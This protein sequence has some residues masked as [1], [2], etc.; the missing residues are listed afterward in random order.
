MESRTGFKPIAQADFLEQMQ[1]E[2]IPF[3]NERKEEGHLQTTG[4]E[5]YYETYLNPQEKASI[6]ISH[7][8]CEFT[9]KFAEVIYYFYREGYSVF[10]LDHRGY[11]HSSRE[12]SDLMK[13]TIRDYDDYVEDLHQ[14]FE[15][16][17]K[18]K[19][20]T[21]KFALYG[22]SM[23]GAIAALLLEKYPGLF[24]CAV[25]TS[26]MLQM[27]IGKYPDFLA[28][29]LIAIMKLL[30]KSTAYAPGERAF[31]E[32]PE[33]ERSCCLSKERYM[34]IYE[35]RVKDQY[36]QTYGATYSWVAASLKAVKKLQKN[37]FRVETPILLFQ[38]EMDTTVKARG[39]NRF[40]A[41]TKD[42]KLVRI[43][44]SKHE[45]YNATD[46]ILAQYYPIIFQYF[47]E[48]LG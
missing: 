14:F 17:V 48:K 30:G 41:N 28:W 10:I 23:G 16:V 5:I 22:H 19:S 7:G 42:T 37:A 6:V 25:L 18:E 31:V 9:T 38:A 21:Q 34:R 4:A 44:K 20:H 8:F 45:I 33:F 36:R 35:E 3:L 29:T 27:N 1:E 12:I 24:Q 32:V 39:Q 46:E 13:V 15:Q 43:A 26:P 47:A 11:G 2:I 40:A